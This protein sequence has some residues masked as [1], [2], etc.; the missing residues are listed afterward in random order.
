MI[1]KTIN[2]GKSHKRNKI[3]LCLGIGAFLPVLLVYFIL[4]F[5]YNNHFYSNSWINGV[6]V[7]NMTV[8]ETEKMINSKV[9]SYVLLLKGRDDISDS[10]SG[11]SI[12]LHTEY[13]VSVNNILAEQNG[14]MWPFSLIK[15]H[16]LKVKTMLE[17][18]DALLKRQIDNIN[19]FEKGNIK[20]PVNAYI[21]DY[22][23]NG[24]KIVPEVLGTKVIK[25][26]LYEEVKKSIDTLAPSLTLENT[27][28]YIKPKINSNYPDLVKALNKMNKIAG[29]KITYQFG[30]NTE[31]LDGSKI[32]EWLS[33]DDKYK[34]TFDPKGIKEYVDN[35]GRTYNSFGRIRTFKTSYGKVIRV[36]GGDYGWWMNRV[37]EV[38]ELT[39]LVLKGKQ[40][41][42]EP[43]Y[44]Q[45]AQQYGPDDV[46]NTYVEVNLTAQHMFF[47][48]DGK[49][50]LDADIVSGNISKKLGTPVGT[51]PIQYRE[52]DATLNGEDYSTPVEYWMPF[53]RNIGLHDAPWRNGR[54]GKNIYITNGSHGCINMPPAKAKKLYQYVSKG[55]PVVVYQL[56]GTETYKKDSDNKRSPQK[57]KK[58][59]IKKE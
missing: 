32:S 50:I 34:V 21:S 59:P 8:Q 41:I 55:V 19:Y 47:Y 46:G 52:R 12:N 44:F 39:D 48:K 20:Q 17:Y 31:V 10:I 24:Y 27:D 13:D 42:K 3:L 40:L 14:F 6:R 36:Q 2:E 16:T 53:N 29:A 58:H 25:K 26:K 45:T 4:S 28:C 7:S 22:S 1:E 9:N 54:F 33:V 23:D 5:Y 56:K 35:I 43:E 57:V 30:E 11:K 18:D 37:A 51:Y 38:S 49:R 15:Q